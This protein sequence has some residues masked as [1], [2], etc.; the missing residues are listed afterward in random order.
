MLTILMPAYNEAKT[1]EHAVGRVVDMQPALGLP[2]EI[3]IVDDGSADRTIEIGERVAAAQSSDQVHIRVLQHG[4]NRGKGAAV[5]TGIA[6]STGDYVVV[7]DADM[8]YDPADLPRL[9]RP[10]Q[11]GRADVVFG[12]R[13]AG[14]ETHRVLYYWHS[15]GNRF[16]TLLSNM[17]TNL[18]LTD[19]EVGYKMFRGDLLRSL[20]L[21]ET[22]FGF[23]PEVTARVAQLRNPR[24]RLYEV[25]IS[26]A[27]RTYADGK[28]ITWRDG[29]RALWCIFRHNI[30]D[31]EEPTN[32]RTGAG[33]WG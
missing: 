33:G 23:E 21:V 20:R 1:L 18:N 8:E 6:A 29:F 4:R 3:L 16:L 9:L 2:L 17:F 28:K 26:Y 32:R 13:F 19:M 11:E 25:G 7:Q 12:S 14:G 30:F 5:H 22:D 10:L 31:R 15:I 24:C 27:G